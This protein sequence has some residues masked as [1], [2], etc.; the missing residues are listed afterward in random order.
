[1]A[2]PQRLPWNPCPE[3]SSRDLGIMVVE[4]LP[5]AREKTSFLARDRLKACDGRGN[6]PSDGLGSGRKSPP[7]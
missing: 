5:I 4:H 7:S 1:M 3:F 6:T 2:L